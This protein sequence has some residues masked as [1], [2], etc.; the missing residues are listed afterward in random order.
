[1]I[2]TAFGCM[3]CDKMFILHKPDL[4]VDVEETFPSLFPF[5]YQIDLGAPIL[6]ESFVITSR[7]VSCRP[8]STAFVGFV[9]YR[10]YS[11]DSVDLSETLLPFKL[12]C[13]LRY[14]LGVFIARVF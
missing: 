3:N 4:R 5:V 1:M 12:A 6:C 13:E 9:V 2:D 7:G 11:I 10:R 14:T 8:C